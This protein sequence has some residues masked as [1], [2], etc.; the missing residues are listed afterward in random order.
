[1]RCPYC[2]G[3]NQDN[4]TFCKRCGRSLS[5]SPNVPSTQRPAVPYPPRPAPPNNTQRPSGAP[6]YPP[7][8]AQ[9]PPAQPVPASQ[10]AT[11]STHY[12]PTAPVIP[13]PVAQPE[14]PV[15]FPP[16]TVK[17]L[18]ALKP[19][20]LPFTV[21]SESVSNKRKQIVRISYPACANWQQVATLCQVLEAV[22]PEKFE[23]TV[24]QGMQ[25]SD[26]SV[27]AFTNGQL[28]FDRD[29][30][31][32]SQILQRYQIETGNGFA[33]DTLRIVLTE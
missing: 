10:Q 4:V 22:Q 1:M 27:Y 21:L 12:A 29:V 16:K 3:F 33:T 30:R 19:S 25:G 6:P 18:M 14:S 5:A 15:P 17:Q 24:I 13:T 26:L 11:R 7:R 23:T 32:G 8:P 28:V 9:R 2:G 31:L 20:A